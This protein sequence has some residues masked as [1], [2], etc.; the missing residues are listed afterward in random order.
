MNTDMNAVGTARERVAYADLLRILSVFAVIVI[1]VAN[2]GELASDIGSLNWH[3]CNLYN[4]SV[5]WAVPVFVM[6]SGMFLLNPDKDVCIRKV[7]GKYVLRILLAIAVWGLFYRCTDIAFSR[8]IR[9]KEISRN[10]AIVE[11]LEIPFGTAWFHL[12]YLY[13]IIGLYV[14]TPIYR[15]FTRYAS[16]KEALYLLAV[17]AL[18]GICLPFLKKILVMVHPRLALNLYVTETVNYTGYFFAGYYFS[19]LSLTKRQRKLLYAAG[20]VAFAVT[21][22]GTAVVSSREGTISELL[23]ENLSPTTMIESVMVFVLARQIWS[24]RNFNERTARIITKLS[25]CAFGIYLIH[26]FVMRLCDMAG[27]TATFISPLFAVPLLSAVT[28]CASLAI[29]LMLRRIPVCR[30]IL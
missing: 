4:T 6:L 7:Y 19:K 17:F 9:H 25:S 24:E 11:I 23:Y 21:A 8:Y 27:L 13:M 16:K 29:I 1:H 10:A 15:V 2:G 28:F 12:W 18:S 5:R 22:V 26:I 3:I 20:I 30:K 14:M